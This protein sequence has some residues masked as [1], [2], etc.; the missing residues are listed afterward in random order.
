MWLKQCQPPHFSWSIPPKIYGDDDDWGM[1]YEIVLT[2]ITPVLPSG[3]H[4]I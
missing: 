2:I 3:K 4:T 1:V